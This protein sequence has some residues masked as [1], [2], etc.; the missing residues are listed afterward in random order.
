MKLGGSGSVV[1]EFP[2]RPKGM[3]RKTYNRFRRSDER[4]GGQISS[5]YDRVIER[6]F[7]RLKK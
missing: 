2:E 5:G 1:D 3:H 4:F 7:R 6:L